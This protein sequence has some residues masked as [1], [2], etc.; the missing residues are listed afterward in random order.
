[1]M[2][3]ENRCNMET[4]EGIIHQAARSFFGV[5]QAPEGRPKVNAKLDNLRFLP[6]RAQTGA[7][8]VPAVLKEKK[9]PILDSERFFLFNLLFEPRLHSHQRKRPADESSD[10]GVAPE[11]KRNRQV[12]RSPVAKAQSR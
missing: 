6:V 2:A 7:T 9:R 11:F 10:C 1:M 5:T 4:I 3:G 12:V 8:E